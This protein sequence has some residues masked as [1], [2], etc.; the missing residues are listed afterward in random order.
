[1]KLNVSVN[2]VNDLFHDL[3]ELLSGQDLADFLD[4]D[5]N[6]DPEIS[7]ETEVQEWVNWFASRMERRHM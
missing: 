7:L 5:A 3:T 2:R 6:L 4:F 1:M